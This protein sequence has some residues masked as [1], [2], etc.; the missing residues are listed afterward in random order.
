MLSRESGESQQSNKDFLLVAF[1]AL[2]VDL[3]LLNV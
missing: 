1:P 2:I 3:W